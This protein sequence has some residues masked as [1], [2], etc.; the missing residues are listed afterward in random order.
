MCIQ[1]E[2][3]IYIQ[4]R[5]SSAPISGYDANWQVFGVEKL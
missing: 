3:I 4:V 2:Y 5:L 1:I